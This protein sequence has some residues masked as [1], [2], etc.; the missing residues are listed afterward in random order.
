[1]PRPTAYDILFEPMQIGP[2]T[3]KNRFYQVPHCTGL[4]WQRPRMVAQLRAI[5]AQGGWGVVN[6]EYCSIHPSSDDSPFPYHSLWDQGDIKAHSIMTE[7]VHEQ[8]ALAGV[9]LWAGGARS[10][11]LFTREVALSTS[12]TPHQPNHP[13][14][15]RRMDKKDI[16]DL[17]QWHKEAALRA[18]Q[19]GFDIVYVYA[20]HHYLLSHFLSPITNTRTD[21]YGGSLNNRL[22]LVRELIEET[23]ETVGER[24]AVA[25]R[26]AADAGLNKQ[27]EIE[28]EEQREMFSMLAEEPDLWDVN[29][30]NYHHEMGPSRFVKEGALEPYMQFVKSVT[31]KPVVTVGRFTSPDTMVSQIRRGISDFI[32][33]A[34]PS[35][36]DPYLPSKI[37]NGQFDDIRE[38]IGCNICYAS[39]SLAVPIRCTQ[40]PTMGEEWRRGWHPEIIAP[41]RSSSRIL[42]VGAGPCGLEAARALG[43]RGYEVVLA[44][45]SDTLGGRVTKEASLPGLSEWIRVRDYR[46]GQLQKM[47]NVSMYLQSKLTKNDVLEVGAQ[48]V[49]LATGSTWRNDGIGRNQYQP[50]AGITAQKHVYTPDDIMANKLPQATTVIFDDDNYYIASVIAE[51]IANTGVEVVYVTPSDKAAAWCDYTDEQF[52]VQQRMMALGIKIITQ[53]TLRAF[54]A[55][56]ATLHCTYTGAA[57]N[58]PAQCLVLVTARQ[59]NDGLHSELEAHLTEQ[60]AGYSAPFNLDKIGDCDAPGLIVDAVFAGHKWARQLDTESSG[61]ELAMKYDRVFY[62][63][64]A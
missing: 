54:D 27:D 32:G 1:M 43:Q 22:R 8:G 6:T 23:K 41:K 56:Q 20:T 50:L 16:R 11:N 52:N 57:S 37:E 58:I 47:V 10:S 30:D 51:K 61:N 9:E 55:K 39:D 45:G 46:V 21:E 29:I 49:I 4:G 48:Q 24:C 33:A 2:V 42:V 36:A 26:F 40:N 35:I 44:E 62:Q 34:R 14:Q 17:R 15:T 3:A 25:V 31:T 19:S 59:P 63:D 7:A 12:S 64:T 18:K 53:K 60:G 5:K 28:Q 13:W 38:C